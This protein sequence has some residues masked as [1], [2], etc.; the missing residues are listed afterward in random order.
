MDTD[1]KF[2]QINQVVSEENERNARIFRI[3]CS[4][5]LKHSFKK[6]LLFFLFCKS[7]TLY[8]IKN[9]LYRELYL[10]DDNNQS[11]GIYII[12]ILYNF[13]NK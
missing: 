13:N 1:C 10:R 6:M 3:E 9:L 5:C 8:F 12:L 4:L 2:D 11:N 7:S